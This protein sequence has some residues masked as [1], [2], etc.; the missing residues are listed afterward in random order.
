MWLCQRGACAHDSK[1]ALRRGL[2]M[3]PA[4]QLNRQLFAVAVYPECPGVFGGRSAGECSPEKGA[5]ESAPWR[6]KS[7]RVLLAPSRQRL[8]A[9]FTQGEGQG[10]YLG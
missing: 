9:L 5:Q 10:L 2:V 3:M 6:K 7:R 1:P 8:R 4:G